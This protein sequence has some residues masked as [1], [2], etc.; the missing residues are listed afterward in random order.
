MGVIYLCT[1]P[2]GKQY[3]GQQ[4]TNHFCAVFRY[5]GNQYSKY[6][7]KFDRETNLKLATEWITTKRKEVKEI[8]EKGSET[9]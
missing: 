3:I 4:K 1:S 6:F 5:K 9:K 8:H 2:S 7:S